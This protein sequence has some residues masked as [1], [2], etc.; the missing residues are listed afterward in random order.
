MRLVCIDF[1]MPKSA[2]NGDLNRMMPYSFVSNCFFYKFAAPYNGEY[3]E[4]ASH[5]LVGGEIPQ[6]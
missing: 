3:G 5:K 6:V 1:D 2:L 4:N